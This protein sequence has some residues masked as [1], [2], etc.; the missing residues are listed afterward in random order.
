MI[1]IMYLYI[2]IYI[3]CEVSVTSVGKTNRNVVLGQSFGP[4]N[5]GCFWHIYV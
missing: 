5:E 3:I 4:S 1:M 2:Y